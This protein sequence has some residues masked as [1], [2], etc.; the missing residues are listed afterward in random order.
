M[1]NHFLWTVTVSCTLIRGVWWRYN[2][3]TWFRDWD[4]N[5]SLMQTVHEIISPPPANLDSEAIISPLWEPKSKEC[6]EVSIH[7]LQFILSSL[8]CRND[9]SFV[10]PKF[11]SQK[12]IFQTILTKKI[13][14]TILSQ[15]QYII[16]MSVKFW[17]VWNKTCWMLLVT[18]L[19]WC[20]MRCWTAL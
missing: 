2:H 16:S 20:I 1:L 5:W 12:F 3:M 14:K 8:N 9:H 7:S 15:S 13:P 10:M 4:K 19:M 6:S 17:F 18:P 11:S